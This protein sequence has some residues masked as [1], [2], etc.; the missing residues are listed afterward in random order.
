MRML[1][2]ICGHTRID[3]I[4]NEVIRERVG[5]VPIEDKMRETRLRWFRHIQGRSIDAP[6]RSCEQL[7]VVGTQRDRMKRT[8]AAQV[9]E[10]LRV[11]AQCGPH[12]TDRGRAAPT[13]DHSKAV[14]TA[15]VSSRTT[16]EGSETW[17]F[18]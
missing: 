11:S 1:R 9:A 17:Q 3:K 2:W 14:A 4:R 6:V 15:L 13:A 5:V 7:A 10:G 16:L 8:M 12:H 18:S